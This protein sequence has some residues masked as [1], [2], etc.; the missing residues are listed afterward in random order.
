MTDNDDQLESR[1]RRA[2]STE[3]AVVQPAGDGLQKI[4]L[5][6]EANARRVWWRS[7]AVALAGAAVLG[8]VASGLYFGFR[9]ND[10][11]GV[12]PPATNHSSTPRPPVSTSPS[13][14]PTPTSSPSDTSTAQDHDGPVYVYYIGHD[15]QGPRLYR[16]IHDGI[17]TGSA[18]ESALRA[19]FAAQPADPDYATPWDNTRLRSYTVAG[20]VAGETATVDLSKFVTLGA[21]LETAAVQEIVYTVT[22]NDP[23]VKQVLLRVKGQAPPSGHSDW[24]GPVRRAPMNQVQAEIWILAP[25]QGATVSS[26]VKIDGYSTTFEATVNWEVRKAGVLIRHGHT[27]GGANG[28]FGPFHTTVS[29]PAGSYELTCFEFSA[30]DGSQVNIDTKNFTVR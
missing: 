26:P 8:L 19:M 25:T 7:P 18:A 9:D 28:V 3:A 4:R 1:L 27:Q 21:E 20:T 6:V 23:A 22:A 16:E 10:S 15:P 2:L 5:G 14:S 24:S 17:G 13:T 12:L 11:V 29:L 30:K